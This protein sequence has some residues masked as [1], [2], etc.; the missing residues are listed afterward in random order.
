MARLYLFVEGRTEQTF[1]DTV[2]SP[3]LASCGVYLRPAVQIAH[4]RR[5]GL[6]HRGGGRKYKPMRDDIERF[7][8][9]ERAS[10][11][12]F[13]TI[14]DLYAIAPDFPGLD[15]AERFRNDPYQRVR[16]L[17]EAWAVDLPDRRFVPFLALHEFETYLLV[18]PEEFGLFYP[19]ERTQI[20]NLRK[21]VDA[22]ASPE[23][24]NDG[25]QTAPS[26]RI[27][28]EFPDYEFSKA[29]V[30]P[31]V[32]ELIGLSLMRKCCPHF[33]IW[34]RLLESLGSIEQESHA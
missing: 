15:D 11:V 18:K 20:A 4:A 14:I 1:A 24:I 32:A 10:D 23:L 31:Q 3:H 6:A 16:S 8:K 30:G 9:Q 28:K 22:H 33:D 5:K 21:I 34:I 26:K 19:D 2:L 27:I 12:F 25:Q 17:Q 7:T 29:A 13:S